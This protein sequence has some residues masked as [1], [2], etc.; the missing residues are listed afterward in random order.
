MS[1]IKLNLC[2][3]LFFQKYLND[4][5]KRENVNKVLVGFK[6]QSSDTDWVTGTVWISPQIHFQVVSLK[7]EWRTAPSGNRP[8]AELSL[9]DPNSLWWE[10]GERFCRHL[11]VG[12]WVNRWRSWKQSRNREQLVSYWLEGTAIGGLAVER[13][14]PW[15]SS[16]LCAGS[17]HSVWWWR[18]SSP[19]WSG[20]GRTASAG[21]LHWCGTAAETRSIWLRFYDADALQLQH[22][23]TQPLKSRFI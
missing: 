7:T 13:L 9:T 16:T 18:L 19:L 15:S 5:R 17:S 23:K 12:T 10:R 4:E 1:V 11:P 14:S 8:T 21:W 20:T 2:S 3:N 22:I 6:P